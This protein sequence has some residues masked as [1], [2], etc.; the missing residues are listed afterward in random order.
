MGLGALAIQVCGGHSGVGVA[1]AIAEG[2]GQRARA[3]LVV[4]RVLPGVNGGVDGDGPHAGGVAITVAV[5]VLS[6]IS[7]GPHI[8]VTQATATL[9][10]TPESTNQSLVFIVST[11]QSLPA[12]CLNQKQEDVLVSAVGFGGKVCLRNQTTQHIKPCSLVTSYQSLALALLPAVTVGS[13]T[14]PLKLAIMALG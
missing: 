3:G 2:G 5:V 8:D 14:G 11:N 1:R 12:N 10:D 6:T 13:G 9:I 4:V 7:T